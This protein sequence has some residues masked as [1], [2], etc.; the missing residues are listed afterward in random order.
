[1]LSAR[2]D[3]CISRQRSWGVPIP[4][5]QCAIVAGSANNQCL[6]DEHS[7]HLRAR[8]IL[9]A[10]DFVIN[11]GGVINIA[12]E[13]EP[14]GYS[15]ACAQARVRHIATVLHDIFAMAERDNL[16]THRAASRLAEQKIATARM[17][18]E[19]KDSKDEACTRTNTR[20]RPHA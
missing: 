10:P 20:V 2:P 12:A 17:A 3:W 15:A 8:G 1:M 9:Y 19:A 4:A 14:A 16:S 5:L 13:M 18:Q 7:D 6:A 11:A